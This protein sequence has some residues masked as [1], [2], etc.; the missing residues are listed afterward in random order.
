[1]ASDRPFVATTVALGAAALAHAAWTWP[2]DAV[3][4]FFAGGAVVVFAAEAVV[5]NAGWLEHHVHPKILG[6]PLYVVPGWLGAVYLWF[7]IALLA[8]DGWPA[9]ALCAVLAAGYDALT[10][11][12]GV[13]AGRWTYTDDLPGPRYR[14]VPWWNYAGWLAISAVTAGLAVPFL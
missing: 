11:H 4:A 1:M 6:V 8:A 7:R 5:V 12:R 9:V 10:D 14:D 2:T 13:E 3:A